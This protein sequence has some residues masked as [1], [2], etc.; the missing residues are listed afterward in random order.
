MLRSLNIINM[1]AEKLLDIASKTIAVLLV[2][3][4]ATCMTPLK[5]WSATLSDAKAALDAAQAARV[6]AGAALD[7]AKSKNA[8]A[9]SALSAARKELTEKN[10][11]H[12][13]AYTKLVAALD[14]AVS[15][16]TDDEAKLAQ[17]LS[18]A[19][20]ALTAFEAEN[21]EALASISPEEVS[22]I[23]QRISAL[24]AS[25]SKGE[26]DK[27]RSVDVKTAKEGQQETLASEIAALSDEISSIASEISALGIDEKQVAADAAATAVQEASDAVSAAQSAYSDASTKASQARSSMNA[28]AA[29]VMLLDANVNDAAAKVNAAETDYDA[30][31]AEHGLKKAT[32]TLSLKDYFKYKGSTYALALM[33]DASGPSGEEIAAATHDHAIND[34]TDYRNV[35]QALQ[36]IKET[37][38]VREAEGVSTLLVSDAMM[39]KE[40]ANVNWSSEHGTHA[41]LSGLENLN[42]NVDPVWGWYDREKAIYEKALET[43]MFE[44]Q[45]LPSD[46]MEKTD[47]WFFSNG[48]EKF[49]LSIGHYR[50]IIDPN[51]RFVGA[52]LNTT[53]TLYPHTYGQVYGGGD[54]TSEL[55]A[56]A[57]TVEEWEADFRAWIDSQLEG[58]QDLQLFD[59]LRAAQAEYRDA[60]A[61][62][63]KAVREYEPLEQS[64][65]NAVSEK[66]TANKAL[67]TAREELSEKQ[68]AETA[69]QSGLASAKEQASVLETNISQKQEDISSK[70]S[71][72]TTLAEEVMAL[73]SNISAI[74]ASLA[75]DREDLAALKLESALIA[76]HADKEAKVESARSA[77]SSVNTDLAELTGYDRDDAFAGNGAKVSA[78]AYTY[79]NADVETVT[80][81]AQALTAVK[82]DVAS[83][84][85]LA[86][87]AAAELTAA[88]VAYDSAVAAETSARR[89]YEDAVR[90]D[91]ENKKVELK[92]AG[93]RLAS[94][95]AVYT[96]KAVTPKVM[97]G[98]KTLISGKDYTLSRVTK[99]VA[100]G[101][102]TV[103]IKGTGAYKGSVSL[104]FDIVPKKVSVSK[105]IAGTK[106]FTVNLASAPTNVDGAKICYSTKKTFASSKTVTSAKGAKA[107][108][109]SG[110]TK[111]KT[112][113]V[114]VRFY[115]KV[116]NKTYYGAWSTVKKVKS[117]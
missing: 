28:A 87:T 113:Y 101:K 78:K 81:T 63:E 57:V 109:V 114:K 56:G 34:A 58:R 32:E 55:A 16:A 85:A 93:V 71:A 22:S 62:Q 46:W 54:G 41:P 92:A 21:A 66:T 20:D 104:S 7:A 18:D 13:S 47:S 70:E 5:A 31:L 117:R 25:I 1:K 77:H 27:T 111:G 94:A 40:T 39:A 102:H 110:L 83:K 91:A 37:N 35:L 36:S 74:E 2:I 80:S 49:F 8:A 14:A 51:H 64:Y 95:S 67:S 33:E 26:A 97:A 112:Y 96:G 75:R 61:F 108:A 99:C 65:K 24:E 89:A 72:K 11:A 53:G 12:Q 84:E 50:N 116:G 45:E 19:E 60:I 29:R 90:A 59:A 73:E 10:L 17:A 107:K 52:A 6:D 105:L 82:N 115:K 42:Y 86:K 48:Y 88:Q 38:R 98:S 3:S 23:K 9:A 103:T 79:L 76:E 43:N 100:I 30:Y 69:V 106:K 68:Q 15:A 4:L 44:E